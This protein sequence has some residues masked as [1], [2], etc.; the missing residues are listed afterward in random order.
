M[1]ENESGVFLKVFPLKIQISGLLCYKPIYHVRRL[2]FK[3]S[4]SGLGNNFFLEKHIG[5]DLY[6]NQYLILCQCLECTLIDNGNGGIN[7]FHVDYEIY[8]N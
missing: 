5:T 1:I 6:F 2:K 7:Y 4:R 3:F 8:L